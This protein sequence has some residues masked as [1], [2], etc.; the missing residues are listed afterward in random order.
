ML[1]FLGSGRKKRPRERLIKVGRDSYLTKRHKPDGIVSKRDTSNTFISV[2]SVRNIH[3]PALDAV[4]GPGLCHASFCSL[5]SGQA[6]RAVYDC[7]GGCNCK[8]PEMSGPAD[9]KNWHKVLTLSKKA[10]P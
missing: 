10:L 2:G 8:L 4:Y 9:K 1:A 3:R 7:E 5:R 6:R